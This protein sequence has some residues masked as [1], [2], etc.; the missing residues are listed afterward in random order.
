[1]DVPIRQLRARGFRL[2]PQR[3]AIMRILTQVGKH[4]TPQEVYDLAIKEI[5]GIT[6]ATVYRTLS[7]LA[8]Q[9]LALEAHIGNGQLVYESAEH[10][11]H[12]L[13]CKI[14]H[15]TCMVD[16]ADL[17]EVF[18]ELEKKTGFQIDN[19]HVTFLGICPECRKHASDC[20]PHDQL[21]D[22]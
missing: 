21:G 22:E 13:V 8:A 17:V 4:R 16:N 12:H 18:C 1:M 11:H 3:L 19:R 7:F 6:E 5:P 14:C 9:G 2:T 10:N 15:G 20:A